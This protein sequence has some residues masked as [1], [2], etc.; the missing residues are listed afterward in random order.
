VHQQA[1]VAA[2]QQGRLQG[3]DGP[4]PD[5]HA[6]QVTQ[7]VLVLGPGA[8]GSP[9]QAAFAQVRSGLG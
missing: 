3:A 5:E 9:S 6:G 8:V 2:A 1:G 7:P 4:S